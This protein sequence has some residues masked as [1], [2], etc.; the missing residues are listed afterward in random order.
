MNIQ[1][2]L[3]KI[4]CALIKRTNL[5]N[6]KKSY[7]AWLSKKY[8]P[9]PSVSFV[10]QSH[11]KSV[12]VKHL[13]GKLRGYS[14]SE[15]IVIDDGSDLAHTRSLAK[16]LTGA[17][18]F[19]I[20]SN[21]LYENVMYDKALRFANG[22]Y[23]AL[24]QDDDDFADYGWIDEAVFYLESTPGLAILGG[25]DGLDFIVD[26]AGRMGTDAPARGVGEA[27]FEFVAHVN[28]APMWINRSLF[29]EKLRHID[30]SFA[31]FQYDDCELC[32]RAWLTG[33][34]VG[35]YDARF[36]SLSAGGMR[37]WNSAFTLSQ[38]ERNGRKLY[39]MYKDKKEE[40]DA[41]VAEARRTKPDYEALRKQKTDCLP[42]GPSSVKA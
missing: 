23:V 14:G 41:L 24:M 19:L 3:S 9:R 6:N 25:R 38:C 31:P 11:N 20:R 42:E 22:R 21:D 29:R 36:T 15:I 27:A 26:H 12:Q 10:I 17:N 2:E 4:Y 32:L 34:K 37:I 18:E 1:L 40:V 5:K 33:L 13:V 8:N 35:R 7:E 28:R 30:F 16:C 39:E